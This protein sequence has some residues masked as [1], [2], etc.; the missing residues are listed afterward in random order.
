[1]EQSI[2]RIR[3]TITP[4]AANIPESFDVTLITALEMIQIMGMGKW[5]CA[6]PLP[7]KVGQRGGLA[8]EN[9][10][11]ARLQYILQGVGVVNPEKTYAA[12]AIK[13]RNY[14]TMDSKITTSIPAQCLPLK[15]RWYLD[16]CLNL[17]QKLNIVDALHV[18]G[19]SRDF[20]QISKRFVEGRPIA[21]SPQNAKSPTAM[22]GLSA[23]LQ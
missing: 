11:Q 22:A 16:C 23:R 4:P 21:E 15:G 12:L 8:V 3:V 7:G 2:D 6:A 17:G 18:L 19:Y 14:R 1:M 10:Q 13:T 9:S 5:E 20:I